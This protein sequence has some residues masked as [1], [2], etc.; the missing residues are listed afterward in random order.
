MSLISDISSGQLRCQEQSF[1]ER[2]SSEDLEHSSKS[3]GQ[4]SCPAEVE[5][6]VLLPIP[7]FYNVTNTLH[8][9]FVI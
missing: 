5:P 2:S 3:N 6:L 4:Q 8:Y 9:I 7:L 1:D